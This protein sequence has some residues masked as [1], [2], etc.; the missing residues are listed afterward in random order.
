MMSDSNDPRID[1]SLDPSLLTDGGLNKCAT[2]ECSNTVATRNEQCDGCRRDDLRTDGGVTIY[3]CDECGE[4]E[5]CN[6]DDAGQRRCPDCGR[7]VTAVVTDGGFEELNAMER[8]ADALEDVAEQMRIQNAA[9]IELTRTLDKLVA[10]EMAGHPDG[11]SGGRRSQRSI[12]GCVEDAA[13][14]LEERVDLDAVGCE[15]GVQL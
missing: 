5:R 3:E 1:G 15:S 7:A 11:G 2:M 4:V 10:V 12:T 6:V 13:I 8:Q 9:L 14:D